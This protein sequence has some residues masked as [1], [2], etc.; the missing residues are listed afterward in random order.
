MTWAAVR[1]AKVTAWDVTVVDSLDQQLIDRAELIT[2]LSA[3]V[4]ALEDENDEL[5]A[6]LRRR[7]RIDRG[8]A[9][10]VVLLLA[11]CAVLR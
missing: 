4:A 11:A 8:V 1:D 6:K 10:A 9:V 3:D 7:R 2:R 5:R